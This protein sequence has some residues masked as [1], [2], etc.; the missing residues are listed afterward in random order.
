ML[1]TTG[2]LL[3]FRNDGLGFIAGMLCHWSQS[4]PVWWERRKAG[5]EGRI[6]LGQEVR[7]WNRED[8]RQAGATT[9]D[10]ETG[11]NRHLFVTGQSWWQSR[12]MNRTAC[13]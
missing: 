5:R 8:I 4:L 13:V 1:V 12:L 6:Q 2:G 10:A 9:F 7:P 11:D 3:A